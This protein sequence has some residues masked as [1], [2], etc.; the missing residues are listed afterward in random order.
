MS[1]AV[2]PSTD[3]VSVE[4]GANVP[5][6]L[7]VVNKG[8]EPDRYELEVEGLDPE[9]VA[10]PVPS[11]PAEV[12]ESHVEKVFFKPPRTSESLAGNYPFVLKVRSLNSGEQRNA[13]GV[14]QIRPFHHVSMEINPRKGFVSPFRKHNSFGI[15]MMNLGNTDHQL[16]LIGS[17]PED[18]CVFEFEHEQVSVS[19]GQQKEVEVVVTPKTSSFMSP[20]RLFGFT[21]NARGVESS[22]GAA[23][24]QAQLEQRAFLSPSTLVFLVFVT[25]LL[26]AW[27][28]MMPKPPTIQMGVS[29]GTI[30]KGESVKI[31]YRAA[32]A[33]QVQILA[34]DTEVVDSNITSDSD[35]MFIPKTGGTVTLTAVAIRGDKRSDPFQATVEVIVPEPA[36][37]PEITSFKA[38]QSSVKVGQN[39]LLTYKFNDA[40]TEAILTPSNQTLDVKS[41]QIEVQITAKGDR[42]FE[43]IAKNRD[44]KSVR[45]A[46][47]VNGLDESLANIIVFRPN[48]TELDYTGGIVNISW[49]VTDAIRVDISDG[50]ETFEV[51]SKGERGFPIS[52]TTTYVL[53]AYDKAGKK[54]TKEVK[55]TVKPQ[56]ELPPDEVYVPSGP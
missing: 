32:N 29:P 49:Q 25:L 35:V 45:K 1:F 7:E 37:D 42:K 27:L 34:G 16:Q 4:A 17:E 3:L 14:L 28:Y 56:P 21:I 22:G 36:P 51:D 47:T 39:V 55:V 26:G 46:V 15:T 13:Q 30:T 53:T 10:I 33:T 40:V 19:P 38:A 20:S 5:L 52:E 11:F 50:T 24:A 8:E 12:G 54:T 48:T 43:I 44:G 18:E 23:S 2:R 41:D 9:W 31:W 6:S